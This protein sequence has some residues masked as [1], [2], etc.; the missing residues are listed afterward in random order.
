MM[1]LINDA[2]ALVEDATKY[3]FCASQKPAGATLKPAD[4][5][6][7]GFGSVW[8]T[9]PVIKKEALRSSK[10][11]EMNTNASTGLDRIA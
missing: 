9:F 10:A 5:A 6:R 3:S 1:L 7:E 11:G 4:I 2:V 8:R